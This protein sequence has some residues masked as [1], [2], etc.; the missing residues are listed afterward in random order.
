MRRFVQC[1][2]ASGLALMG[3]ALSLSGCS[4]F[5]PGPSE[6]E[7]ERISRHVREDMTMDDAEAELQGL[8]YLCEHRT[9]SFYDDRGRERQADHFLMCTKRPGWFSFYCT[10]RDQ[11]IVVPRGGR[12]GNWYVVSGPSCINE[13]KPEGSDI[14]PAPGGNNGGEQGEPHNAYPGT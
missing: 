2:L 6:G 5:Y 10:T 7:I 11:V 9:G 8:S 3:L 14:N 4:W 13:T 1:R 12:V